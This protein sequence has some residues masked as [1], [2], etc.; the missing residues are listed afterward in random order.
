MGRTQEIIYLLADLVR[1]QRLSPLKVYVDSQWPARRRASR[2]HIRPASDDETRDL[3]A[4]LQTH[5]AKMKIEFVADVEHSRALNEVRS[6]AVIISASGM[7]DAGRIKYHLRSLS[8][9]GN[10]AS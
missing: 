4:W 3:I 10:A 8:R 1:R 7:C 6:G 5:P 9:S 2:W